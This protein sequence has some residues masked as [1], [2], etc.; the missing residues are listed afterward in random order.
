MSS[1]H[2]LTWLNIRRNK[3]SSLKAPLLASPS[4]ESKP[5]ALERAQGPGL[6]RRADGPIIGLMKA[7]KGL[8]IFGPCC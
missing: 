6:I 8:E 3:K 4:Q 2:R 1:I 5:E 7:S